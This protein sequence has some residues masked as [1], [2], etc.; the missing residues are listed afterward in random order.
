MAVGDGLGG[1]GVAVGIGVGVESS[2]VG[3]TGVAVDCVDKTAV[4]VAVLVGAGEARTRTLAVGD[5]AGPT[6]PSPGLPAT[7]SAVGSP[8]SV[9]RGSSVGNAVGLEVAV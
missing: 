4:A 3:G 1:R 5:T 9:S 8:V 2:K 6:L 7:D